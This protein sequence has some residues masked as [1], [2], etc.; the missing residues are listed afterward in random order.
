MVVIFFWQIKSKLRK[1]C[2]KLK[3]HQFSFNRLNRTGYHNYRAKFRYFTSLPPSLLF[4]MFL[5]LLT[6]RLETPLKWNLM[7]C[8]ICSIFELTLMLPLKEEWRKNWRGFLGDNSSSSNKCLQ[9][10]IPF[11]DIANNLECFGPL[12]LPSIKSKPK[13]KI[14]FL[15]Y[16]NQSKFD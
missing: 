14:N 4:A 13:L 15:K 5:F 9:I 1:L 8:P 10:L 6:S 2:I 11:L 7:L 16:K 3:I 12:F